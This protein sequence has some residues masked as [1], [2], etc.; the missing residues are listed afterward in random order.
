MV[1]TEFKEIL[2][3]AVIRYASNCHIINLHIHK[4][5]FQVQIDN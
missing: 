5:L 3:Q 2:G 4:A 1:Q